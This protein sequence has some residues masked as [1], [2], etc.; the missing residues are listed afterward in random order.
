MKKNTYFSMI[1]KKDL[2][3][4]TIKSFLIRL[5]NLKKH[6][7]KDTEEEYKK[8]F[9]EASLS[10]HFFNIYTYCFSETR[11]QKYLNKI[12]D[13]TETE[14]TDLNDKLDSYLKSIPFED[15]YKTAYRNLRSEALRELYIKKLSSL[16]SISA[17][18]LQKDF[19][20]YAES[21]R[22]IEKKKEA[23][24]FPLLLAKTFDLGFTP[25]IPNCYEESHNIVSFETKNESMRLC[26]IFV[27]SSKI[28]S[29]INGKTKTYLKILMKYM[30]KNVEIVESTRDLIKTERLSNTFGDYGFLID[31]P[32]ASKIA[33]FIADYMLD[34]QYKIKN[35]IGRLQ[36][37]W[38]DQT[39]YLP[40]RDQA[41]VWLEPN[42]KK[43]YV[44][45]GSKED[46]KLLLKELAKGK[47]FINVLGSFASSLFGIVNP[48]NFFIHNGGLT[49]GGKSLAVKCAL[50]FFGEP[51]KMGN[52]W[53]AT[54]N[55]LESY[56]EQNHSMPMWID[57]MEVAS[58]VENIILAVYAFTDKRGKLRAY[59]KDE[60]VKQRETKSFK[61]ICFT[62]GEKS[63]AEV[64]DMVT[65]RVKPR[66]VTRRVLDLNIK[67][68]WDNVD[69]EVIKPLLDNNC[70]LLGID[71]VEYL[72]A[73]YTQ[74][75][76]DFNNQ[77]SFFK[78]LVDGEKANQFGILK[79]ALE[80]LYKMELLNS[81]EYETQITNLKYFAKQESSK[82]SIIKD[83]FTEFK[84]SYT[85]F[86]F[87]NKE[88]FDFI[89]PY[90]S[91][92]SYS[93]DPYLGK[94]D[95][96]NNLV[97][98]FKN[99]FKTWCH[100]NNFVKDQVL[101]T[102][103]DKK[104]LNINKGRENYRDIAVKFGDKNHKKVV[105]CYQFARLLEVDPD[106]IEVV[107]EKV[108]ETAETLTTEAAVKVVNNE[109]LFSSKETE[110]E[111]PF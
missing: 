34:N 2:A 66:G 76:A 74:I 25:Y 22:A 61:G 43:A 13:L 20:D 35:E 39:Y 57:E 63:F 99:S 14:F 94:V 95:L 5:S 96:S 100:D 89:S 79:L 62:T 50:S 17:R 86:I 64:Q 91:D 98:V 8:F 71:Y 32:R 3:D 81:Y 101:E 33:K 10:D 49:E 45:K 24:K 28:T 102:L 26:N 15:H 11:I 67:D 60:E 75:K 4:T 21:Q 7:I 27:P 47:V 107:F 9:K 31:N 53:N 29:E 58:K 6:K 84:E 44:T 110:D 48:M 104:H 52:N 77:I 59:A 111:I 90:E 42:L 46:Q 36:T 85:E 93:K 68:L 106:D 41:V 97:T 70:G 105:K 103:D 56:W 69:L 72:E 109:S 92:T 51:E 80:V 83:T 55:G 23:S 12:A 30:N 38:R 19:K 87:S 40:S 16:T 37:G 88:H 1:F 54:L 108:A 78:G 65:N 18:S 73:N 82:L